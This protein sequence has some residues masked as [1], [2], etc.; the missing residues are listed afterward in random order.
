MLL[1]KSS[2]IHSRV[3]R[4]VF[5]Q[6]KVQNVTENQVVHPEIVVSFILK[7]HSLRLLVVPSVPSAFHTCL[8][9]YECPPK[10]LSNKLANKL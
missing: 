7:P 3:T 6:G 9:W 4:G 5:S 10:A 8:V 2:L 1:P